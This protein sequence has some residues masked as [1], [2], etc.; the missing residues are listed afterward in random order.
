MSALLP[1]GRLRWVLL[2]AASLA[3]IA[4]FL[5]ATATANTELFA[6]GYD[7]LLILNG[8]LVG[9]LIGIVVWQIARLR[10]DLKRGVFGSRLASRLVLLFALVAVLPG[11]LV[12]AVSVQF[13]GRHDYTTPTAPVARWIESVTAPSKDVVWF[14]NSAHLCMFEEPGKFV[15]SLTALLLPHSGA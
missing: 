7:T 12:Y 14:E 11:A 6:Q 13:L 1:P 10:R 3:A 15:V 8:V 5:L 9:V 4:L 2:A